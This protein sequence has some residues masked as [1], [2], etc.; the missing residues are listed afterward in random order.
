MVAQTTAAPCERPTA[1][2]T[3]TVRFTSAGRA[4]TVRLDL[5]AAAAGRRVPVLLALHFASGT[6]AEMA[7]ETRLSPT[8]TRAGLAAAYP[9]SMTPGSWDLRGPRDV[10]QIADLLDALA[11]VACVDDAHVFATGVSNGAS[12]S[13]RLG[14]SLAERLAGIAPVAPGLRAI[15]PCTTGRQLAVLEIHGLDDRVVPYSGRA[16]AGAVLP[17][18][19]SWAQRDDCGAKPVATRV[20]RG[21]TRLR[22][23]G[24]AA[25]ATVEHLRLAGT[26]HGWPGSGGRFPR[27]DPTGLRATTV[28]T[29]WAAGLSASGA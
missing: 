18:L 22:W 13:A 27:H 25:A 26:D 16:G 9:S 23:R 8:T 17:W 1:A 6:G 29:R 20:R 12:M 3:T 15:A 7:R 4:R 11:G 21:I 5:P 24:C 2:G 28:V 19:R 14:C 10:R